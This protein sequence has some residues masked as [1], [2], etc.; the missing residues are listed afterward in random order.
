[1]AKNWVVALALLVLPSCSESR[2]EEAP[3]EKA[4]STDTNLDIDKR[5]YD[6]PKTS[7]LGTDRTRP[8]AKTV[9]W[10]AVS[11]NEGTTY[12][13][14]TAV[15]DKIFRQ[16]ADDFYAVG[17]RIG[18]RTTQPLKLEYRILFYDKNGARVLSLETDFRN[19]IV[20]PR[21][22][23]VVSDGCRTKGAVGFRL[24]VR[25]AG[26]KDDGLPDGAVVK[27]DEKK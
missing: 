18:N 16:D 13:A 24:F 14:G 15:I 20:E 3:D 1:M 7:E 19:F 27:K 6:H 17:V 9:D 5:I 21:D 4:S 26:S 12:Q 10:P 23:T 11:T 8:I 2:V 22:V 25:A